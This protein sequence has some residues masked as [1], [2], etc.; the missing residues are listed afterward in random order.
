M[1][2]VLILAMVFNCSLHCPFKTGSRLA[3][4]GKC[5][6]GGRPN[7]RHGIPPLLTLSLYTGSRLADEG[8]CGDGDRPNSRHGVPPFLTLSL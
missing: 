6:D 8:K 3:D 1:V 7:S 4:K 5:G 2:I